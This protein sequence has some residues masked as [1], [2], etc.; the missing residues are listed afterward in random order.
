MN[1]DRIQLASILE[2][3]RPWAAYALADLDEPLFSL[4]EWLVAR[5][6]VWLIYHGLEPAVLLGFGATEQLT[7]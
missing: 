6:A 3:D 5:D 7:G 4:C 2:R 1:V